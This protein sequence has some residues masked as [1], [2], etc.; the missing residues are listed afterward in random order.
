M[1][2]KKFI[3][4]Y[5]LQF[6]TESSSCEEIDVVPPPTS[7]DA[8]IVPTGNTYKLLIGKDW[9]V[10]ISRARDYEMRQQCGYFKGPGVKEH[11]EGKFDDQLDRPLLMQFLLERCRTDHI[12]KFTVKEIQTNIRK[13]VYVIV[14][15][16]HTLKAANVLSSYITTATIKDKAIVWLDNFIASL[17]EV[18]PAT[19]PSACRKTKPKPK[20]FFRGKD[21]RV[22]EQLQKVENLYSEPESAR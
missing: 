22:L 15:Q 2:C 5:F 1:K 13:K 10:A 7:A 17:P 11:V 3:V 18:H 12:T 4:F 8:I 16:I 21:M 20:P 19:S 9:F 14:K 6:P